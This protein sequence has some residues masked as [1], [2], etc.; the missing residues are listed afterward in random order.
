LAFK[1]NRMNRKTLRQIVEI[2]FSVKTWSCVKFGTLIN[3][4]CADI[5]KCFYRILYFYKNSKRAYV[6]G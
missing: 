2:F 3:T 5:G 1:L 6:W 4:F